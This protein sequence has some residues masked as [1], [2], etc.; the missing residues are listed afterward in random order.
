MCGRRRAGS[1]SG[2]ERGRGA[3]GLEPLRVGPLA[4]GRRA[5]AGP[6]RRRPTRAYA[7]PGAAVRP[8]AGWPRAVYLVLPTVRLRPW[9]AVGNNSAGVVAVWRSSARYG[10]PD[11][12]L[13]GGSRDKNS[14]SSR[15]LLSFWSRASPRCSSPR[16]F[17]STLAG[18]FA[19]RLEFGGRRRHPAPR[20]LLFLVLLLAPPSAE[21]HASTSV[22]CSRRGLSSRIGGSTGPCCLRCQWVTA[23]HAAWAAPVPASSLVAVAHAPRPSLEPGW[24]AW[25][26]PVME[27]ASRHR[28]AHP[29]VRGPD[30]DRASRAAL[31]EG[32]TRTVLQ[33]PPLR[34]GR[35]APRWVCA[36]AF[37][38]RRLHPFN[39]QQERAAGRIPCWC[40][41][42]ERPCQG[43]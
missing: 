23:A 18:S 12:W 6:G 34:R 31:A 32:P 13:A 33:E 29:R 10:A 25:P 11:G 35:P 8:A 9:G 43:L 42:E 17:S 5:R 30:P 4:G 3:P 40:Q 22:R 27:E 28:A 41:A 26:G 7:G 37:G 21:A 19:G 38:C 1:R 2:R 14:S 36:E 39:S 16:A 20:P 15:C 24:G